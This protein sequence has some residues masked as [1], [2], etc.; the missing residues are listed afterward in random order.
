MS[1]E[2][3]AELS[4]ERKWSHIHTVM[5]YIQNME[6]VY[7]MRR[8]LNPHH[9]KKTVKEESRNLRVDQYQRYSHIKDLYAQHRD[10]MVNTLESKVFAEAKNILEQVFT[11][12]LDD[13]LH[14]V[15]D[16]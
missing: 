2:E 15:L 14:T 9:P 13:A 10:E 7:E 5:T 11:M 6:N 4:L 16:E 3:F 12:E 1:D 8:R